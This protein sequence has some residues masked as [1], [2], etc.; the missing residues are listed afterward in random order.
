MSDNQPSSRQLLIQKIAAIV[1]AAMVSAMVV[2]AGA[3]SAIT[4]YRFNDDIKLAGNWP[5]LGFIPALLVAAAFGLLAWRMPNWKLFIIGQIVVSAIV[6]GL[7]L[8]IFG[9]GL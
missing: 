6:F 8:L 9:T 2:F 7:L 5:M 4:R 3:A 1:F